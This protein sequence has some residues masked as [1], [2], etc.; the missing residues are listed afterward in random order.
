MV[1]VHCPVQGACPQDEVFSR[2]TQTDADRMWAGS[3]MFGLKAK[4]IAASNIV[5]QRRKSS[6]KAGLIL[7]FPIFTAHH[8]RYTFRYIL[9]QTPYRSPKRNQEVELL[10]GRRRSEILHK[11]RS[12][13]REGEA[14][15][16]SIA[17]CELLKNI[18]EGRSLTAVVP[19]L[20]NQ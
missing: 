18:L 4:K 8:I 2:I 5:G 14:A 16:K 19:T 11:L 9:M 20:A 6:I 7:E 12:Q 17:E 1:T 3:R 15:H 10:I 13:G